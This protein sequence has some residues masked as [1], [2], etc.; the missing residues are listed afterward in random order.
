MAELAV[1]DAKGKAAFFN[2]ARIVSVSKGK[3]G[4]DC[5]AAG[6]ILRSTTSRPSTCSD[7]SRAWWPT[8]VS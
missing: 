5:V 3:V 6:N 4:R 8:A 7:H 1:I 2:G